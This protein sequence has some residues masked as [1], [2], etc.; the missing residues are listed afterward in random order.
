MKSN[1][2]TNTG[3]S[4]KTHHVANRIY[5][6][7]AYP[8]IAQFPIFLFYLL[9][10]IIP[11]LIYVESDIN[12]GTYCTLLLDK[13]NLV[14]LIVSAFIFALILTVL[15][16]LN[17][18]C[19]YVFMIT[20]AVFTVGEVFTYFHQHTRLNFNIIELC[21][22][23]NPTEA[24]EFAS[25][26]GLMKALGPALLIV[27]GILFAM[28]ILQFFWNKTLPQSKLFNKF[29]ASLKLRNSL[30]ICILAAC[31]LSTAA[32]IYI[33]KSCF[34]NMVLDN[35]QSTIC[36]A[37]IYHLNDIRRLSQ[38][39]DRY[40][41]DKIIEANN[42]I[43]V[44]SPGYDS[45]KVVYIIGESHNRHRSSAYG[46]FLET[47][48]NINRHIKDSSLLA[49][50]NVVAAYNHTK[51]SYPRLL[52]TI[53]VGSG[54]EYS[55]FPITAAVFKKAGFKTYMFNN[56]SSTGSFSADMSCDFIFF[57]KEIRRQSYDSISQYPSKYDIDFISQ[58]K[59]SK[60]GQ[61]FTTYHLMGQH[62][63]CNE[64]YKPSDAVFSEHDYDFITEYSNE[65]RKEMAHY[66]NS[67][68][69]VDKLINTIIS[70]LIDE[71]AIVV[72][73]PDHGET[74]Y[75]TDHTLGRQIN[76]TPHVIR[77]Q[78]EVP[79]Y[80][81][82][83]QLYRTKHSDNWNKLK[84]NINKPIY[85]IDIAHTLIDLA[86]IKTNA[87]D[88]KLSLLSRLQPRPKRMIT[89]NLDK[90]YEEVQKQCN[91]LKTF[92]PSNVKRK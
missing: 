1:N 25:T 30:S 36:N 26:P 5:N 44:Y 84:Q 90:N 42:N 65:E 37:Q 88:T 86:G 78:F 41:V 64:R 7:C 70:Q 63:P 8:F 4:G 49:F 57:N 77:N 48:P 22:Q 38:M 80:I 71:Y 62:T 72:Y 33:W 6:L 92:Y 85:N 45:L 58:H 21:L 11:A 54:K 82:A 40:N 75:D 16:E 87:L 51:D 2:Q 24:S 15:S 81:W 83:S 20:T 13:F 9:C 79:L 56:Q 55:D 76:Y 61:T 68:I 59:P 52:S 43:A 14:Y 28:F 39:R 3:T 89:H 73:V 19:K 67:T 10:S 35:A 29:N 69:A 66:D 60:I 18:F 74:V 50:T 32:N 12:R 53:N 47:E 46:Y 23:S 27:T 34:T 31:I 91:A 17:K